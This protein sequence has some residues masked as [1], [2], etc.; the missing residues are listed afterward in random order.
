MMMTKQYHDITRYHV[1]VLQATKTADLFFNGSEAEKN[2]A[3]MEVVKKTREEGGEESDAAAVNAKANAEIA[4][5][6]E[7]EANK[8]RFETADEQLLEVYVSCLNNMAACQL[9]LGEHAK[10]KEICVRVLEIQPNNLKALLR[11]AKAAL[12]THVRNFI[13]WR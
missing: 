6:T 3:L 9:K 8:R 2:N 1:H 13:I 12:A 11:A 4:A 10:A 5:L 7:A